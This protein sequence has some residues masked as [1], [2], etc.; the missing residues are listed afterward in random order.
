[1]KNKMQR[2]HKH[3]Y[4]DTKEYET[5]KPGLIGELK[6]LGSHE[7]EVDGLEVDAIARATYT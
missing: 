3:A 5:V 2:D 4:K 7:P 6:K 1:M